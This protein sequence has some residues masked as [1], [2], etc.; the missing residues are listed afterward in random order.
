MKPANILTNIGAASAAGPPYAGAIYLR[1][2]QA[3]SYRLPRDLAFGE[4]DELLE[5]L[6]PATQ[7]KL[8]TAARIEVV[9]G[10]GPHLYLS[11]TS[12]VGFAA[13]G[14]DNDR[15]FVRILPKVG[16]MQMLALAIA[17]GRLPKW[18]AD[19]PIEPD[20]SSTL[21]EWT[22][23]AFISALEKLIRAGGVRSTHE[24]IRATLRSRVRG[25]LLIPQFVNSLARGRP[26]HVPCE[27][28]MLQV[29]NAPNRVLR[30]TIRV[31]L[32]LLDILENSAALKVT[33]R[34]LEHYFD[35]PLAPPN[36]HTL[37]LSL[38]PNLRHYAPALDLA[39]ALLKGMNVSV[40]PGA[41]SAPSVS[42]D[43]ND[44][45]EDAFFKLSK[46]LRPSLEKKPNWAFVL[47]QFGSNNPVK[48]L[49]LQP[50][51]YMRQDSQGCAVV[52]DTKWKDIFSTKSELQLQVWNDDQMLVRPRT[53]DLYQLL[54]YGAEVTR[55]G[56]SASRCL[57]AIVYPCLG[58]Q[59]PVFHDL[60]IG[61]VRITIVLL[62]W[63]L[64][65][66]IAVSASKIWT[67]VDV[68]RA[69][70]MV[71]AAPIPVA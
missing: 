21:I 63:N 27:F 7:S 64:E 52:V 10:I 22:V 40:N 19:V 36:L 37:S 53:S 9:P 60:E 29:D 49:R 2:H 28:S 56:R 30:W 57:C 31:A 35:V 47:R 16:P 38:P 45:Y 33:L 25:K 67:K 68:M 44:L 1:E 55:R 59:S 66:D 34:R 51:I 18:R 65:T 69:A 43:M 62:G 3:R 14:Q 8:L 4:L 70:M 41:A 17:A 58:E 39:V 46:E 12:F 13:C 6:R 23:R 54:S 71:P 5:F 11:T 61:D 50:D 32:Q 24:R 15:I 20:D 26:D 42:L 48:T